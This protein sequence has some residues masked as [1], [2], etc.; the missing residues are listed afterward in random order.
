MK[1]SALLLA[2]VVAAAAPVGAEMTVTPVSWQYAPG[3]S[4]PSLSVRI[5]RQ[6]TL[7]EWSTL[8]GL[9][10]SRFDAQAATAEGQFD[11]LNRSLEDADVERIIRQTGVA[12]DAAPMA[13]LAAR[14]RGAG[15]ALRH[16]ATEY[17]AR[18]DDAR[19]T[20]TSRG[21]LTSFEIQLLENY[22]L[23]STQ[24]VYSRFSSEVNELIFPARTAAAASRRPQRVAVYRAF[25]R[26][27]MRRYLD[28]VPAIGAT[29]DYE[30]EF[31]GLARRSWPLVD[32]PTSTA[33]LARFSDLEQSVLDQMMSRKRDEFAADML[34]AE[35]PASAPALV[36]KWRGRVAALARAHLISA[37]AIAAPAGARPDLELE[38]MARAGKTDG[39]ATTALGQLSSFEAGYLS[40][41]LH[42]LDASYWPQFERLGAEADAAVEHGDARAGIRL[43]A[44]ALAP[45]RRDLR[46]YV[47]A[48]GAPAPDTELK[49][50]AEANLRPGATLA[51]TAPASAD[52][53]GTLAPAG[54]IET[55]RFAA[56]KRLLGSPE[57]AAVADFLLDSMH[58]SE[59]TPLLVLS[60]MPQ[61][62]PQRQAKA[63]EWRRKAVERMREQ[64]VR[65]DA[66]LTLR[67]QRYG[68]SD[69]SLKTYYCAHPA[70]ASAAA[71]AAAAPSALGQL[72]AAAGSAPAAGPGPE[73]AAAAV[74]FERTPEIDRLCAPP[75]SPVASAPPAAA[76]AAA[77]AAPAPAA[78]AS[79]PSSVAAV[80]SAAFPSGFSSAAAPAEGRGKADG[81]AMGAGIGMLAMGAGALLLGLGPGAVLGLALFGLFY[82]AGLALMAES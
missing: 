71:P 27:E 13:A 11:A 59:A 20:A 82:G 73:A 28:T 30:G 58:P 51:R 5:Q 78:P 52:P 37:G 26:G 77:P 12:V 66:A 60:R 39:R 80:A 1:P 42:R 79:V 65:P 48:N 31:A 74:S 3:A 10:M 76:P 45:M 19:L 40:S 69:A 56:L 68:L 70:P 6:F 63:L 24:D 8:K 36:Q 46:A 16:V 57:E 54:P 34:A 67:L 25:L 38:F 2:A 29:I 44:A 22:L 23:F 14:L 62:D 47:D 53:A 18:S 35:N 32:A 75:P 7:L 64:L 33:F 81:V 43:V 17:L 21:E 41:R 9:G 61:S 55:E 4:A 50:W 72:V 49:T 15:G